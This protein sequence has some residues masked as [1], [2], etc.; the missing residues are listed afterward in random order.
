VLEVGLGGRLDA[1]NVFDSDCAIVTNIALDHQDY[2]G[3][4]REA[5]AFEKSGVYRSDRPAICGDENPPAKLINHARAIQANLLCIQQDFKFEP[6]Q[7]GFSYTLNEQGVQYQSAISQIGLSGQFQY[8]NAACAITA[9][10]CLRDQLPLKTDAIDKALT[11]LSLT[12]RFEVLSAGR[13]YPAIIFDVAH[14][15][16]VIDDWHIGTI[17][18]PRGASGRQLSEVV[19]SLSPDTSVT[20]DATIGDAFEAA[21]ARAQTYV[22]S[23]KTVKILVFG[24]FFTVSDVKLRLQQ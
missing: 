7:S 16:P 2:L 3:D 17:E 13:Q 8:N 5:I 1:V 20:V 9:T 21:V 11:S 6:Q 14:N 15:P 19:R 23:H 4:T 24:S 10:R 22:N 18:H 12:G